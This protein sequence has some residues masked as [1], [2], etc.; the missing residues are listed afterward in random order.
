VGGGGEMRWVSGKERDRNG[1]VRKGDK[2]E[3][4]ERGGLERR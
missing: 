4:G 2:G 3:G 1:G